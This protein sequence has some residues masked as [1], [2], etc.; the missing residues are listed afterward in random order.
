MTTVAEFWDPRHIGAGGHY[1]DPRDGGRRRHRGADWSHGIG[2]PILSPL[3]GTVTGKLAP[4]NWHGFGYQVTIRSISGAVFSF[5][6][7]N[8]PSPLA[9]GATVRVGDI[10]GREGTT[11]ATTGPCVHVEY[12][13]GGFSDPEPQIAAL[14][15]NHPSTA[16]AST[17]GKLVFSQVVKDRQA[18]LISQGYDLGKWGADGLP[19]S[20]YKAAVGKY[21]TYLKSRGW[22]SGAIDDDWGPL[23]QAGHVKR[24]AEL[25]REP[26]AKPAPTASYPTV[27]VAILGQ[28]GNVEGL[29]KIARIGGYKGK[30]DNKWGAGSQAGFQSWLNR[31]YGGSV[32]NWL[33]RKWGYVGNDQL[34]P[35]MTA[36]LQKANAA[37][38]RA[39]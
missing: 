13:N 20:M 15:S 17:G 29:Q 32:A 36:A 26:V 30:I 12:N 10:I 9:L 6:H 38:K 14:I 5:A 19:G 11:G 3:S 34:G 8:G 31:N 37:N 23:T 27:S 18:F 28:I 2:T 16:P 35:I 22:Y 4:A 25:N 1:G 7:M 21:Q 39:L 33:R 24:W